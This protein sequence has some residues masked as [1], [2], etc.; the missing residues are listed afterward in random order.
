MPKPKTGIFL[1]LGKRKPRASHNR[2]ALLATFPTYPQISRTRQEKGGNEEYG[3][4]ALGK[5]CA[6]FAQNH[7]GSASIPGMGRFAV[8]ACC[9]RPECRLSDFPYRLATLT[10]HA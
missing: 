6:E 3:D 9:T 7:L 1:F 4:V 10:R 8:P 2:F 5:A